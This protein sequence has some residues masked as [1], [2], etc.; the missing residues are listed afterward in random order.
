MKNKKTILAGFLVL[1]IL[2]PSINALSI[3]ANDEKCCFLGT[4]YGGVGWVT[5]GY[6][7]AVIPFASIEIEGVRKKL[8]NF[9]GRYMFTGLQLDRTYKVIADAPG[10]ESDSCSV[11][12]TQDAPCEEVYIFLRKN[13]EK[14]E[15]T[16]E[17]NTKSFI[18]DIIQ[19]I[20]GKIRNPRIM[21][22]GSNKLLIF[23]AEKVFLIGFTFSYDGAKSITQWIYSEEVK[24]GLRTN[25]PDF[26][27]LIT[28]NFI[29]GRQKH[30]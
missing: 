27:G 1:M 7:G 10:Y 21:E 3:K 17:I 12:L 5:G 11:T 2:I 16:S 6:S 4:I 18:G 26:R 20:I 25:G 15:R 19:I 30:F 9:I 28:N 13:D 14:Y 8:C 24:L 22:A 23:F 29:L